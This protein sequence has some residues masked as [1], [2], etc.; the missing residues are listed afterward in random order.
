MN[1]SKQKF[2][3]TV[4]FLLII[5]TVLAV[6]GGAVLNSLAPHFPLRNEQIA[7]ITPQ[8]IKEQYLK[9]VDMQVDENSAKVRV[10]LHIKKKPKR[11]VGQLIVE[12][13]P[14]NKT[15][16]RFSLNAEGGSVPF[17][18]SPLILPGYGIY[19]VPLNLDNLQ[20]EKRVKIILEFYDL[21]QK[22]KITETS[23]ELTIQV[24]DS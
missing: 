3:R 12:N 15:G 23:R 19:E 8:K 22:K 14:T 6:G 2:G 21:D 11:R 9:E 17:F 20:K 13:L 18:Q 4:L 16:L 5:L 7:R 24:M 10:S 1:R